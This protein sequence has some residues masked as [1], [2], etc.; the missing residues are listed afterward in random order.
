MILKK[1]FLDLN[2]ALVVIFCSDVV[3]IIKQRRERDDAERLYLVR[4]RW[5]ASINEWP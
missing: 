3:T 2:L 5:T 1:P 4:P